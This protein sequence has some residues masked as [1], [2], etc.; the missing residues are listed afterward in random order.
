MNS[1]PMTRQQHLLICLAEECAEVAQR[2]SKALRFGLQEIQP[3][4]HLTNAER[5][6]DEAIDLQA[7]LKMLTDGKHLDL[8]VD[9][10]RR[11]DLKIA[12]VCEFLRYSKSQGTLVDE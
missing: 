10:R 4:Q 1:L 3:G 11:T 8:G 6:A 5:L 9:A 7:V 2:A 12:K